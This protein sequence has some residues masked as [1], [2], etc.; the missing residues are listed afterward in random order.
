MNNYVYVAHNNAGQTVS[1]AITILQLKAGAN[2]PLEILRA[3]VAQTGL[4]ASAMQ[5]VNL[6]RKTAAA[7]VTA[8]TALKNNP[9][10]PAAGAVGGTAATGYT[11]TVEGTDGDILVAGAFNVLNG[12]EWLPTPEERITVDAAGILA[13]KFPAAPTSAAWKAAIWFRELR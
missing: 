5:A 13:L 2:T 1:T 11:A 8:F 9:N 10:D 6:L 12:W 7:T 3:S 4:S